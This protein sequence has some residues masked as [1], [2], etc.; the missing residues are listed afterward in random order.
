[1]SVATAKRALRLP[2]LLAVGA[3]AIG[4]AGCGLDHRTTLTGVSQDELS[5][6]NEPYFNVGPITYQVQESRQLNPFAPD[7]AQY[8]AGLPKAQE[9]GAQELWYGVF[10]WAKNQT[11]RPQTTTDRFEIVDSGGTVY[12][13]TPLSP[14]INPYAWTA[15]TLDQNGIE[16][17]PDTTASYGPV[18]GGLVLFKLNDSVYS[19]RPLTLEIFAPGSSRPSKVSLDL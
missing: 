6:G 8:F 10:L 1:M 3:I 5:A 15:Q 14:S 4:V 7:D 19:N 12:Q 2:L 16:P 17:G 13:P 9:I 18:G 11:K